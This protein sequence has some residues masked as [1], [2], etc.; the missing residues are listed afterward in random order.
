MKKLVRVLAFTLALVS[1]LSLIG[2]GKKEDEGW[3]VDLGD[4]DPNA[5]AK[6]ILIIVDG[7]R[8]DALTDI[9][10]AQAVKKRAYYT[11][12]AQT[13]MPCITLPSHVSI[14][15]SVD[16]EVHGT[17]ENT[18]VDYD[19]VS[20][21]DVLT[22]GEK[23]SCMF[24]SYD[25]LYNLKK[26]ENKVHTYRVK[27]GIYNGGEVNTILAEDCIA[28][29]Q[30]KDPDFSFLYL[31]W[32]DSFGHT[33]SWMSEEYIT[34]LHNSWDNIQKVIDAFGKTH[35]IIISADHGGHNKGHGKDIPEDMTVPMFILDKNIPAGEIPGDVSTKDIAPT[36]VDL[37][38]LTPDAAWDGKSLLP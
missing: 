32:P 24:F 4:P 35:S 13:V 9:Q 11:E 3:K 34:A 30:E 6:T 27:A 8:P 22:E 37:L 16:P 19:G 38:G 7:M 25:Q 21:F 5:P 18:Y 36:I 33:Y 26:K 17:T 29:I 31:G 1:L 20:L 2:C 28:Y 12:K 14:F 10:Q 23:E 15:W